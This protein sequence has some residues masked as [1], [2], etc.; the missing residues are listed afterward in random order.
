MIHLRSIALKRIPTQKT[1]PFSM[2]LIRNL[3]EISFKADIT[4]LVGENGSGKSTLLEGIAAAAGSITVGSESVSQDQSLRHI[5]A[6]ADELKLVWNKRT[7]RGFF[8]RSEDFFGYAK[9]IAQ[10]QADLRADLEQ[11]DRDYKDRSDY[12]KTLAKMS[13]AGQLGA[14]KESYGD[15]LDAQSHGESFFKLFQKR[16]VPDGLYLLDEPEAP[17]SP[18]R[19]LTFLTMLSM[20]IKQNAQFIIATHSPILLAYPGAQ[21]L[22]CD[23]ETLQESRYEDLEHVNV[24]RSFLDN[25]DAYLRHLIEP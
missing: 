16:L 6:F 4:F 8:M 22:S 20:A 3:T 23:G 10:T 5:Q 19:Q 24:M 25:P 7:R 9:Q 13:A 17:L 2:P 21:I 12:A 18:T 15:G 11:V 14:L 1:F